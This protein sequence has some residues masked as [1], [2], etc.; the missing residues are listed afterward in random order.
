M[1]KVRNAGGVAE[2]WANKTSGATAEYEQ[3]VRNP[4]NSWAQGAQAA[5]EAYKTGVTQA[6][7]SGRYEKGV[8]AAGDAAWSQGAL[9][10]GVGRFAGGVQAGIN[11]YASRVSKYLQVIEST[12]LPPRQ[13]KGSPANL[14]RVSVMAE[15]LR[16]A[17]GA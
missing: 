3:G 11:K 4:R 15:A 16:K 13:S 10:V 12:S 1:P 5:K 2:K 7:Q 9:D 14:Q 17:R 6:A 8:A